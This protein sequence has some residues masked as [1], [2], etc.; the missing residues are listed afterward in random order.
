M[1]TNLTNCPN[2]G[3]PLDYSDRCKYC[4]TVINRQ[5]F[6][7]CRVIRP[8]LRKLAVKGQCVINPYTDEEKTAPMIAEHLKRDMVYKLAEK[9]TEAVKI[10]ISKDYN[11]YLCQDVILMKGELWVADHDPSEND[12]IIF[13]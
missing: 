6:V 13:Y 2:C 9:L 12:H 1:K 3:A 10:T 11:P 5:D 4:G 7:E 8:G